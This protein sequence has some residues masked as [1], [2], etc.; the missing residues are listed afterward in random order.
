[1]TWT[2]TSGGVGTSP[3]TAANW[4]EAEETRRQ[5]RRFLV[6]GLLSV[7]TDLC[8]YAVLSATFELSVTWA[9]AI[10]YLAGVVVGFALNKR[11]TF[12]SSRRTWTEPISYLLLYAVT[13]G[14]NVGCNGL[15]LSWLIDQKLIAFL[16]ATGVTTVINFVGMRLVTFRGGVNDRRQ[17]VAAKIAKPRA[18]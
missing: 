15:V 6:V 5:L 14:V 7:A 16:F 11:W 10:S 18:A 1:M 13:L 12:Q 3:V 8:V 9:K 4:S 17:A 2:T